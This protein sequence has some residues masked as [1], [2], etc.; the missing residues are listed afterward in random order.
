MVVTPGPVEWKRGSGL[1]GLV[2]HRLVNQVVSAPRVGSYPGER[3]WGTHTPC[4][5]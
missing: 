2:G 1:L 5:R 3:R 4:A